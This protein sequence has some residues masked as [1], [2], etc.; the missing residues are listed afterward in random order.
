MP[1]VPPGP[2]PR[3]LLAG[4]CHPVH[5]Y[6]D[7]L[8]PRQVLRVH[9]QSGPG[10]APPECTH[11]RVCRDVFPAGPGDSPHTRLERQPRPAHRP[12][13][14][15]EHP[16]T[17]TIQTGSAPPAFPLRPEPPRCDPVHRT[18]EPV[19]GCSLSNSPLLQRTTRPG[20]PSRAR[21]RTLPP[22][23]EPGHVLPEACS[24][25]SRHAAIFAPALP[26]QQGHA[27]HA[28]PPPQA[29]G[30]SAQAGPAPPAHLRGLLLRS[31]TWF[32]GTGRHDKI[33][34]TTNS[35]FY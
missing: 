6:L 34:C 26:S 35:S 33:I 14:S 31:L 10:H 7:T 18:A 23:A 22:A 21:P 15:S 12:G 28:E 2:T 25:T 8:T 4:C 5:C 27:L 11:C 19:T 13:D 24:P 30:G 16:G 29:A 17:G 3:G 1:P 32:S 9:G 20:V